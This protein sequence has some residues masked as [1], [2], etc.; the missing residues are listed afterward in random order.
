[1]RVSVLLL[2]LKLS[3]L[4]SPVR[5]VGCMGMVHWELWGK[6]VCFCPQ[7]AEVDLQFWL[8]LFCVCCP[9]GFC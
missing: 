4:S 1:M 7:L 8:A 6:V 5:L 9:S 3:G 2:G